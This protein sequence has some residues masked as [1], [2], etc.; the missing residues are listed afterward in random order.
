MIH[1]FLVGADALSQCQQAPGQQAQTPIEASNHRNQH[2][3]EWSC[4]HTLTRASF[5][6]VLKPNIIRHTHWWRLVQIIA[7]M[8]VDEHC[9]SQSKMLMSSL[10]HAICTTDSQYYL[11]C[12]L[13]STSQSPKRAVCTTDS[14]CTCQ[15]SE[16]WSASWQGAN[17]CRK[18]AHGW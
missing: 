4:M 14:R 17:L 6:F 13:A 9:I 3:H 18:L 15:S 8:P 5:V 2:I 10:R 1:E 11:A 7:G 16:H 12:M